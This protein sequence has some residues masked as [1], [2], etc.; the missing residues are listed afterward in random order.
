M[1]Y[2]YPDKGEILKLSITSKK[3]MTER[4]LLN[5]FLGFF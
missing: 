3:F 4:L 1:Y 5:C 2:I